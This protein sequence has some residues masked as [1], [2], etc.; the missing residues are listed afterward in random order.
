MVTAAPALQFYDVT[1]E[2]A[3][4]CDGS[5]SGLGAVQMQDGHPIAY[6]SKALTTIATTLIRLITTTLIRPPFFIGP[7]VKPN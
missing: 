1:K 7:I 6:A 4:Q 3:I 2:V 5:S